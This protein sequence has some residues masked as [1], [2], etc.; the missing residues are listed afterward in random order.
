MDKYFGEAKKFLVT[1]IPRCNVVLKISLIYIWTRD[2]IP[3]NACTIYPGNLSLQSREMQLNN[4][5][6]RSYTTHVVE[7]M[8]LIDGWYRYN[9]GWYGSL[10]R[11]VSSELILVLD[12]VY[13]YALLAPFVVVAG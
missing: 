5:G 8:L 2:F 3:S 7:L 4:V 13:L 11:S 12:I 1:G 9:C 6:A 10:T